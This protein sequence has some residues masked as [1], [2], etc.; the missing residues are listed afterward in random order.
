MASVNLL[1]N[2][3]PKGKIIEYHPWI[4]DAILFK[5]RINSNNYCLNLLFIPADFR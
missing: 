4:I 5:F 1:M 2:L 3:T